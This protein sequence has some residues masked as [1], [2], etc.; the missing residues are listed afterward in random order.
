M[1]AFLSMGDYGAVVK[2]GGGRGGGKKWG[3]NPTGRPVTRQWSRSLRTCVN[4]GSGGLNPAVASPTLGG[5]SGGDDDE[6]VVM[7]ADDAR[8]EHCGG[9]HASM[10]LFAQALVQDIPLE[11]NDAASMNSAAI[12]GPNPPLQGEEEVCEKEEQVGSDPSSNAHQFLMDRYIREHVQRFMSY[13]EYA[14]NTTKAIEACRT[15]A[16]LWADKYAGAAMPDEQRTDMQDVGDEQRTDMQDVGAEGLV[17][18]LTPVVC[19]C[20][21]RWS[22]SRNPKPK[23][24]IPI[25]PNAMDLVV[26]IMETIVDAMEDTSRFPDRDPDPDPAPD[27]YGYVHVTE[28][29]FDPS[30]NNVLYHLANQFWGT[31]VEE[32]KYTFQPL[33]VLQEALHCAHPLLKG[34]SFEDLIFDYKIREFVLDYSSR[35]DEQ[36]ALMVNTHHSRYELEYLC[37]IF[38]VRTRHMSGATHPTEHIIHRILW[39]LNWAEGV[40]PGCGAAISLASFY[41][42][43]SPTNKRKRDWNHFIYSSRSILD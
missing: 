31:K 6:G 27:P 40:K 35:L 2:L 13:A 5:L 28:E 11:H 4:E 17:K 37:K 22:T 9:N 23:A 39:E 14:G 26:A 24:F 36:I 16:S 12:P 20:M 42:D 3:R 33:L 29:Q 32:P 7:L 41:K 15:A 18:S 21:Q 38:K 25:V 19:Q 8:W 34:G 30:M 43:A 1:L 10:Q